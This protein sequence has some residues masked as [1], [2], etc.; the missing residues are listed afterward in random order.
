MAGSRFLPPPFPRSCALS[1][2][3]LAS[4]HTPGQAISKQASSTSADSNSDNK[5]NCIPG[6]PGVGLLQ[7][8]VYDF[9][10]SELGTPL[11]DE[12]YTHLWLVAR[13][14]GKSVDPLNRQRVKIREII[15]TEDVHLHLVW[16]HNR[17]Y[18]KPM[19][20]CL[21]NYDFWATYLPSL[22]DEKSPSQEVTALQ[23]IPSTLVFDRKVALGFMR[24]YALLVR[25]RVDFVLARDSHLL[26][27][28]L[29]WAKWSE[30][31]VHFRRIEDRDVAKRYHYGQLRLSRLN[32]AVRLFRPSC[33]TTTWFYEIPHS[34]TGWYLKQ[35]IT[36]LLFGFASLSMVLSSMQVLLAVPDEGLGLHRVHVSSLVAMRQAF[37]IF[38]IIIL[39]VSGVIWALLF[40][41]PSVAIIW[42]LIWGFKNRA[43]SSAE[44]SI[45][46]KK[47]GSS[48][49]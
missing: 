33:A 20:L 46:L 13:K 16:H 34:S 22:A 43:D 35:A 8:T 19:P 2:Q 15:A 32:W 45:Q 9:L 31:I 41:I 21:L 6:E 28:E 10:G 29:D 40:V 25:H 1:N 4:V 26:P 49:V 3:R 42:Q 24:S 44:G 48:N 17:I 30:F 18:V 38:S 5:I 23:Q 47:E 7:S 14:F 11:L 37:W 12:L 27:A 39:L 36:P